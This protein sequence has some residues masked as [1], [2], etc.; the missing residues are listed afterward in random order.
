MNIIFNSNQKVLIFFII[1]FLYGFKVIIA[2]LGLSSDY[3]EPIKGVFNILSILICALAA[4]SF[5]KKQQLIIIILGVWMIYNYIFYNNYN[6]YDYIVLLS[7][8]F[9]CQSIT[10]E[11]VIGALFYSNVIIILLIIPLLFFSEHFVM[12]DIKV[13]M[14]YTYGFIHPNIIAQYITSLFFMFCTF[15]FCKFKNRVFRFFFILAIY[16][17]TVLLILPTQSRTS[18]IILSISAFLLLFYSHEVRLSDISKIKKYSI[19]FMLIII[20]LFQ[21]LGCIY[22]RD[23]TFLFPLD[24]LLSG[25]LYQG[26]QLYISFGFPPLIHGFN[27]QEFMPIDFYFIGSLYSVGFLFTILTLL[28]LL[29]MLKKAQLDGVM[30][31]VILMNLLTTFTE[32]HFQIPIYCIALFILASRKEPVKGN[33][34]RNQGITL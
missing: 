29:Y 26:N 20:F 27:I 7:L 30:Y 17:F 6:L 33:E 10:Y 9:I 15:A 18:I 13:G 2:S 28:F 16:V 24:Y 4:I 12:N 3:V 25:R 19:F 5:N 8:V 32:Y 31:I 14:R 22:F 23:Y 11:K 34:F 1:Y 21:F